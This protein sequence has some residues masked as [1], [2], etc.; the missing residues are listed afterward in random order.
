MKIAEDTTN[1]VMLLLVLRSVCAQNHGAVKV[2]EEYHNLGS[3]H[4]AVCFRQKKSVSNAAYADEVLDRYESSIFTSG[5]FVFGQAVYDS[6]LSDLPTPKTF[7][8]NLLFKSCRF[9]PQ[10]LRK[11]ESQQST[12][13]LFYIN[14]FLLWYVSKSVCYDLFLHCQH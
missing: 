13:Q 5:K 11:T 2:D 4:A 10:C 9:A 3:V 7:I 6:V 8:Y 14:Y 1:L 12:R